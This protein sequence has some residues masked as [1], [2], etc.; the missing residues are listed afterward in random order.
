MLVGP[1]LVESGGGVRG[2]VAVDVLAEAGVT[3]RERERAGCDRRA[4]DE[5]RDRHAAVGVG[6]HRREPCLGLAPQAGCG[7]PVGAR[8]DREQS[9]PLMVSAQ[10]P[11][12]L[13]MSA[14]SALSAWGAECAARSAASVLGPPRQRPDCAR[15]GDR[16]KRGSA[17][18]G[19]PPSSRSKFTGAAARCSWAH[20]R[21]A[22]RWPTSRSSTCCQI[23]SRP[24]PR[25]SSKATCPATC[26]RCRACSPARRVTLDQR[27]VVISIR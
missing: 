22:P 3:R 14:R 4:A 21:T 19:W 8:L 18:P 10:L 24:R 16:R 6:T 5:L 2:D 13:M 1:G 7:Q 25:V 20:R 26:T 23:S 27:C 15:P 12:M 9:R 17:R 11:P